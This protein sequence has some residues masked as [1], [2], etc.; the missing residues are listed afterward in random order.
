MKNT[1][2][3]LTIGVLVSF[4][5]ACNSSSTDNTKT[6]AGITGLFNADIA[7]STVSWRGEMI[8]GAYFHTGTIGLSEG[9]ITFENG[10]VTGGSFMIDMKTITT[11]DN[12]YDS[13]KKSLPS[14]LIGHL[15]SP[16]FFAVDSFPTAKFEITGADSTGIT[17]NLTIR[18]ITNAEKIQNI[19]IAKQDSSVNVKG[20]LTFD[21]TKYDIKYQNAAKDMVLSNDVQ[22]NVELI[23]R[24]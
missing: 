8:G 10:N 23:A 13:A 11:T 21:R 12:N 17:G 18:G 4:I 7:A 15:G 2:K 16:D 19:V 24:P 5:A 22:L 1:I 6:E 3:F 9:M 14:G 20:T